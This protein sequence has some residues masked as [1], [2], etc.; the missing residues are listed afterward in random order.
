MSAPRRAYLHVQE[1]ERVDGVRHSKWPHN[2]LARTPVDVAIY[3]QHGV[4]VLLPRVLLQ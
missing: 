3:P 1:E 2:A 4:G